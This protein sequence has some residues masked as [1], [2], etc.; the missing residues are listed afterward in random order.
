MM[1]ACIFFNR[2]NPSHYK[3]KRSCNNIQKKNLKEI[4]INKYLKTK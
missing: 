4:I 1:K 2:S 3:K